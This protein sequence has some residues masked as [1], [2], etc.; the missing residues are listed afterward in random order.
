[1]QLKQHDVSYLW[2]IVDSKNTGIVNSELERKNIN[3][4]IMGLW[5]AL[6]KTDMSSGG[7]DDSNQ[8]LSRVG[9]RLKG[10]LCGGNM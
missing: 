9:T 1:M 6:W 3:K 5:R 7:Q 4:I 2:I 8:G 10:P